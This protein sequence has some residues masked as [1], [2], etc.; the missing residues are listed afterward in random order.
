MFLVNFNN[1]IIACL[2]MD[3][4][5]QFF[6]NV[7]G[8]ILIKDFTI[9]EQDCSFIFFVVLKVIIT[10]CLSSFIQFV[11]FSFPEMVFKG[12]RRSKIF[13]SKNVLYRS[14]FQKMKKKKKI[15]KHFCFLTIPVSS[16]SRWPPFNSSS[17][18]YNATSWRHTCTK[19]IYRSKSYVK[20]WVI[21]FVGSY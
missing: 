9:W 2:F 12:E 5:S 8:Q 3:P 4:C 14:H 19:R 6:F 7:K 21:I 20:W 16:C 17:V 10:K 11:V 18:N 15:L 1:W 13:L